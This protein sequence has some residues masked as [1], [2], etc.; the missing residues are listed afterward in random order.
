MHIA[1]VHGFFFY[2]TFNSHTRRRVE[3]VEMGSPQWEMTPGCNGDYSPPTQRCSPSP[4]VM[5]QPHQ[6]VQAF[7]SL[8]RPSH[9]P[10]YLTAPAATAK[11]LH[12]STTTLTP[13]LMAL[14]SYSQPQPPKWGSTMLSTAFECHQITCPPPRV[15]KRGAGRVVGSAAHNLSA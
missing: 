3:S 13:Q 14:L 10:A 4:P 9:P 11:S 5:A 8:A 6:K 1:A 2:S 15:N 7:A 12:L